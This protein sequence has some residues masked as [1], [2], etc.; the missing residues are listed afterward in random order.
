MAVVGTQQQNVTEILHSF[1]FSLMSA[2][3]AWTIFSVAFSLKSREYLG[4]WANWPLGMA[5]VTEWQFIN[6]PASSLFLFTATKPDLLPRS[7]EILSRDALLRQ[8]SEG[9]FTFMH[10]AVGIILNFIIM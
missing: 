5:R 4:M 2:V 6:M 8:G 9:I 1:L 3:I 10:Y 7:K